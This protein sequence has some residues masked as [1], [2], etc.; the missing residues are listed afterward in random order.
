MLAETAQA[1]VIAVKHPRK[2]GIGPLIDRVS[3]SREWTQVPRHVLYLH[4]AHAELPERTLVALKPSAP[5]RPRSQAMRLDV[6]GQACRMI[7]GDYLELSPEEAEGEEVSASER[8]ALED[9][10]LLLT[11]RLQ[12][13]EQRACEI[14]VWAEQACVS[15][16]T[17]RRAKKLLGVTSHP[18]GANDDRHFVWKLPER[19]DK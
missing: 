3:G 14:K 16:M 11:D 19:K 4:A 10:K 17:L 1:V 5:S 15:P 2:G 8:D 12:E 7:L 18:V 9:A 13:G 6:G